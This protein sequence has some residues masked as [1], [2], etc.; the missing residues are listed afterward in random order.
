[1]FQYSIDLN[2]ISYQFLW[3]KRCCAYTCSSVHFWE[4]RERVCK[5]KKECVYMK[6]DYARD[7]MCVCVREREREKERERE[8]SQCETTMCTTMIEW[9]LQS[10]QSLH[11]SPQLQGHLIAV[12]LGREEPLPCNDGNVHKTETTPPPFKIKYTE[13]KKQWEWTGTY[14]G[15]YSRLYNQPISFGRQKCWEVLGTF[16]TWKGQNLTAFITWIKR[17]G[18]KKWLTSH[19]PKSEMI[20][21]Q[22]DQHWNCFEGNCEGTLRDQMECVCAFLS[23]ST[24]FWG[25]AGRKRDHLTPFVLFVHKEKDKELSVSLGTHTAFAS[26]Y[27]QNIASSLHLCVWLF[28]PSNVQAISQMGDGVC[29]A[30]VSGP[31][32]MFV[33][34]ICVTAG[35]FSLPLRTKIKSWRPTK[36]P[37]CQVAITL[38]VILT[39]HVLYHTKPHHTNC[40]PRPQDP[41]TTYYSRYFEGSERLVL[42]YVC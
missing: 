4:E 17:S 11:A 33:F 39:L 1:M 18:E 38:L 6:R 42:Y 14:S 41:G 15:K 27:L 2:S 24:P 29:L 20:D 28:G 7:K 34:V 35:R 19:P 3:Y 21:V 37:L 32:C 36:Q 12:S 13:K 25:E 30:S 22:P 5:S 8:R 16:W 9:Q 10:T 31:V 40:S 23:A 26:M